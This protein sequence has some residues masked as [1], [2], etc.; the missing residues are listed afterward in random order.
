MAISSGVVLDYFLN[1]GISDA[2]VLV[3]T[4]TGSLYSQSKSNPDGTF[5][6]SIPDGY[7]S[8]YYIPVKDG[9]IG[10][11]MKY[12]SDDTII[13]LFLRQNTLGAPNISGTYSFTFDND[14]LY[15][16]NTVRDIKA[17]PCHIYVATNGGLDIIDINTIENVGYIVY[18]G[19]F[20]CIALNKGYCAKSPVLLG[21]TNSGVLEFP[22]P[23]SYDS[24]NKNQTNSLRLKWAASNNRLLSNIVTSI[25][26]NLTNNYVI[27]TVS[28]IDFY[29]TSG[30]RY[31]FQYNSELDTDCCAISEFNDLYYSPTNSGVYVKYSPVTSNWSSVD[32]IVKLSGT[33]DNPFP[34]LSNYIND[35]AITSISGQNSVFLATQSGLVAYDENRSNLNVSASGAKLIRNYP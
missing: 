11:T 5:N 2:I 29:T 13:S 15:T 7:A 12:L 9:Y 27:G 19:G 32:Y 1:T 24:S 23:R 25:D 28:G 22:I 18:S 35:I 17:S 33:G 8:L 16:G 34:L 14:I 26:Q 10:Y 20:N 4:I 31:Y 30:A 6:I 3:Y 21:T